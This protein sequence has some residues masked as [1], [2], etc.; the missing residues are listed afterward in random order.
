MTRQAPWAPVRNGFSVDEDFHRRNLKY[1]EDYLEGGNVGSRQLAEGAVDQ[2]ALGAGAVTD[3]AVNDVSAS[4]I[5]AGVLRSDVTVTG[6]VATATTGQRVYMDSNGLHFADAA[7]NILM[8]LPAAEGEAFLK[9]VIE[10]VGLIVDGKM[11]LRDDGSTEGHLV[12]PGT[13]ITLGGSTTTGSNNIANPAAKPGLTQVWE[14]TTLGSGSTALSARY[15]L[16]WDATN[17]SWWT[18]R[19]EYIYEY[20]A[21]GTFIR[22]S[23]VNNVAEIHGAVRVGT[24]VYVL[25]EDLDG[26]TVLKA[27]LETDLSFLG[28]ANVG[29]RAGVASINGGPCIGDDGTNVIICDLDAESASAKL[30]IHKFTRADTPDFVSTTVTSGTGNPTFNEE[31]T[32]V[33]G[34]AS[35]ESLWWI[36]CDTLVYAFSTAGVYS[37]DRTF[38]SNGGSPPRGVAHDG[39]QFWTLMSDARICKH[40]NWVWTTESSRYWV[41]YTW[42]DDNGAASA[43]SRPLGAGDFETKKSPSNQIALWRRGRLRVTVPTFPSTITHAGIYMDRGSAEP[44]LDFVADTSDK[45]EEFV[46]FTAGGNAPPSSNGFTTSTGQSQLQTSDGAALIRSNGIPRVILEYLAGG[47]LTNNTDMYVR[48]GTETTDTDSFWAATTDALNSV[49]TSAYDITLPFDGQYEVVVTASFGAN[50]TNRRDLGVELNGTIFRRMNY[51]PASGTVSHRCGFTEVIP[52]SSGDTLRFFALQNSGA[53]LALDNYRVSV[54][55]LGPV[56]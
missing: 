15:G 29:D 2:A 35:A 45:S 51:A 48:F 39:T 22:S 21:N 25:Y 14:T 27:L 55:F 31:D 5:T 23:R 30:R 28:Q 50:A 37:A 17:T 13:K 49:P 34:F 47:T 43:G 36:A 32:N 46:T 52:A 26:D 56:T 11:T 38:A 33:W 12:E 20:D 40:T 44:T 19:G 7:G 8:E 53:G 10:A 41:A 24:R 16:T 9:G 42:V 3:A 54:Q 18:S 6:S 4:K 1:F